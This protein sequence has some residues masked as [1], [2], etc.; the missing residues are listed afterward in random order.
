MNLS[1]IS[2]LGKEG[3]LCRGTIS[4]GGSIE[5]TRAIIHVIGI[6]CGVP[7]AL[8]CFRVARRVIE[9]KQ[10]PQR[11]PTYLSAYSAASA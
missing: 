9:E 6:Y 7:Q 10:A 8:G 5:E 4:N 3:I 2:A 11:T 1:M